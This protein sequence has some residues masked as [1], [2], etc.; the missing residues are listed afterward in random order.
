M[1][2][3]KN[4]SWLVTAACLAVGTVFGACA[5]TIGVA[6]GYFGASETPSLSAAY[7]TFVVYGVG[8]FSF[9]F[10]KAISLYRQSFEP[11]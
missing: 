5:T 4:T 9:G 6:V 1:L 10:K 7:Y 11:F 2:K 8:L 3:S